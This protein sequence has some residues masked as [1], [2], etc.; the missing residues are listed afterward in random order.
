MRGRN[1]NFD[2]NYKLNQYRNYFILELNIMIYKH[3]DKDKKKSHIDND[4]IISIGVT[5]IS[6]ND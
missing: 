6:V 5:E 4:N 1:I 3:L 2:Y